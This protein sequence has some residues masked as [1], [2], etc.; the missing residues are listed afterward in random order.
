MAG[1]SNRKEKYKCLIFFVNHQPTLHRMKKCLNL[2][3]S[4]VM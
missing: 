3:M 1:W 2:K 4:T